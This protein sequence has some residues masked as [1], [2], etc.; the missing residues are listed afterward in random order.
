MEGFAIEQMMKELRAA[1]IKVSTILHD[2]DSSTLRNVMD[3]F[4]DVKEALCLG[5]FHQCC[6]WIRRDTI[7]T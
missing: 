5:K 1:G 3:I 4:E 2:K 6:Q 7:D